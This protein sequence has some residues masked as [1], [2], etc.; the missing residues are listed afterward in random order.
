MRMFQKED[1]T[2]EK[3]ILLFV[4]KK[5]IYTEGGK[6]PSRQRTDKTPYIW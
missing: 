2:P 4:T 3:F 1:C 5:I 6:A